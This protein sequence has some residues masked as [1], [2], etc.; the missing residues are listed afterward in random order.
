MYMRS[1]L[2]T[3]VDLP[4]NA[5]WHQY[6]VRCENARAYYPTPTMA[7]VK[8]GNKYEIPAQHFATNISAASKFYFLNENS[9]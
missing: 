2:K 4:E 3:A 8:M 1:T 9:L 6:C 7:I 5:K